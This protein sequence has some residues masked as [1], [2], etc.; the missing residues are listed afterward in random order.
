MLTH[1]ITR[2]FMAATLV[3]VAGASSATTL[4]RMGLEELTKTNEAVVVGRVLETNSHWNEGGTFILTDVTLRP[5][6]VLKGAPTT[7]PITFTVMGGSIGE[8]TTLIVAGVELSA[9]ADVLLFLSHADLP[10]ANGVLT[11][12]DHSQGAFDLVTGPDGLR[13]ISQARVHPLLSDDRGIAEPPGGAEG[14]PM[15][16]MLSE[17]TRFAANNRK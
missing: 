14:L 3:A 7:E 17:V 15:N 16:F 8:L 1:R 13:A 4:R 12:R 11:V 9:G 2:L 6:A 5:S 10:G